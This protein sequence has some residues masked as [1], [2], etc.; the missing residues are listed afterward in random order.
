MPE[1][2]RH[3]CCSLPKPCRHSSK[4]PMSYPPIAGA[5]LPALVDRQRRPG[6]RRIERRTGRPDRHR[7][8]RALIDLQRAQLRITARDHA[9]TPNES[10]AVELRPIGDIALDQ[11]AGE[12]TPMLDPVI[13]HSLSPLLAM[14]LLRSMNEVGAVCHP[15]RRDAAAEVC[16]TA[17]DRRV[18]DGQVTVP[19]EDRAAAAAAVLCFLR[20]AATSECWRE[21]CCS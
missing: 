10:F 9:S 13:A 21:R 3:G 4:A 6:I 18:E 2:I 14:M 1:R 17:A 11:I 12:G 5:I 15:A 19:G 7:G 8:S 20:K 16:Q